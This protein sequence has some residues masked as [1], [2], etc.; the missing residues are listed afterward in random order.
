MKV[1]H[2]TA[3]K[4]EYTA[5]QTRIRSM[6]RRLNKALVAH[7]LKAAAQPDNWDYARSLAVVEATLE[8][9]L[10]EVRP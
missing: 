5:R 2:T 10:A 6:I 4:R 9:A 8:R 7:G 3:A 1:S